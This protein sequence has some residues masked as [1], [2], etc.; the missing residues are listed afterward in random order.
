MNH[1]NRVVVTGMGTVSA[2]GPDQ[3]AFTQSLK[4]IKSGIGPFTTGP[5]DAPNWVAAA[6]QDFDASGIGEKQLATMDRVSQFAVVAAREAV[7]QSGL[8][9]RTDLGLRTGA[10]L[11][12]GAGG[13][14]T[15]D[16]GFHR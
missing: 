6:V 2:L 15:L 7:T 10:I 16:S 14:T 13:M 3:H 9:F 8:D 5:A 4:H 1:M 11:G 12:T